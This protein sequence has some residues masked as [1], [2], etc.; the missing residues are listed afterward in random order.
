VPGLVH[1]FPLKDSRNSIRGKPGTQGVLDGLVGVE[2]CTRGGFLDNQG[3]DRSL[4]A[5]GVTLPPF[6]TA[7]NTGSSA[8]FAYLSHNSSDR[9]GQGAVL[10]RRE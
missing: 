10:V 2:P 7:W 9:T 8:I 1:D 5:S 6:L 4:N 3:N